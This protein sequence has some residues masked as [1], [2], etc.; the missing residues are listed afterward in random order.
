MVGG[1]S[2]LLV[3]HSF[4]A[5]EKRRVRQR[6]IFLVKNAIVYTLSYTTAESDFAAESAVLDVMVAS[7]RLN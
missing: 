4:D 1:R 2:G 3:E 6:Q 5:P 7:F